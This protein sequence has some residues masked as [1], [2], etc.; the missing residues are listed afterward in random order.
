MWQNG[1]VAFTEP[2]NWYPGYPGTLYDCGVVYNV[3]LNSASVDADGFKGKFGL[4]KC[5][6]P[7]I[8][9]NPSLCQRVAPTTC[10]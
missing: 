4:E 9:T 1:A 8:K 10:T 2:A 5:D 3:V 6:N 7:G